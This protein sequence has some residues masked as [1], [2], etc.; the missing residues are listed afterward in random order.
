M[1]LFF[2]TSVHTFAQEFGIRA[3]SELVSIPARVPPPAMLR[4]HESGSEKTCAPI[5]GKWN[6]IGMRMIN[7]E[8]W[9]AGLVL[10]FS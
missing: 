10:S 8:H 6:K 4:Y 5:I 9:S 1:K 7:R 3:S 2:T